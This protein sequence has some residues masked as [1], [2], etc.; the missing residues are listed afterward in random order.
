MVVTALAT[1]V[2]VI[3]MYVNAQ[4]EKERA[5]AKWLLTVLRIQDDNNEKA[6]SIQVVNS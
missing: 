1:V 5:P 3:I 6:K 2:A 4:A